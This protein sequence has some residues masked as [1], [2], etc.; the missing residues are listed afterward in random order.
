M[1]K[2]LLVVTALLLLSVASS[3]HAQTSLTLD[4]VTGSRAGTSGSTVGWGFTLANDTGYLLATGADFVLDPASPVIGTFSDFSGFNSVVVGPAPET[5]EWQQAFD[6]LAHT[7]I[8]SFTIDPAAVAGLTAF[9]NMVLTYDLF[10]LSPND[11]SFDPDI[12]L[13]SMGNQLVSPASVTV[14]AV[15]EPS[16]L[17]LLGAGLAGLVLVR[18]QRRV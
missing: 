18:R 13:I 5:P 11:P 2:K 1:F 3:A 14:A 7:G 8:G 17:I 6:A 10:S 16:T 9:G 15:P 12:N 4:P